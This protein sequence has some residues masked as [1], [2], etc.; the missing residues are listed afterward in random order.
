MVNTCYVNSEISLD[1]CL[2]A[3]THHHHL[4][5][6]TTIA[7]F[8]RSLPHLRSWIWWANIYNYYIICIYI[9]YLYYMKNKARNRFWIRALSTRGNLWRKKTASNI[10]W[11]RIKSCREIFLANFLIIFLITHGTRRIFCYQHTSK[12][13]NHLKFVMKSESP[14]FYSHYVTWIRKQTDG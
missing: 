8:R 10:L 4:S 5:R 12:R 6:R 11:L 14:F 13:I 2:C 1:I 9:I 3:T 7:L